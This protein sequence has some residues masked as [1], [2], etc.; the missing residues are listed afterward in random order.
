MFLFLYIYVHLDTKEQ[1]PRIQDKI[2]EQRLD[3]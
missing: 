3:K 2:Y 1:I